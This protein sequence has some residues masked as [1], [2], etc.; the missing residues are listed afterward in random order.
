MTFKNPIDDFISFSSL[1]GINFNL[2]PS[3]GG[4]GGREGEREG[5][6]EREREVLSKLHSWQNAGWELDGRVDLKIK[7]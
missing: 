4:G 7:P 5:E 6:R 2:G 3:L 1:K